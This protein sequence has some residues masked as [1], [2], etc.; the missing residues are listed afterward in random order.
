MSSAVSLLSHR[1]LEVIQELSRDS[2][3]D[4]SALRKEA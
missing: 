1:K 2:W 4:Q 3:P